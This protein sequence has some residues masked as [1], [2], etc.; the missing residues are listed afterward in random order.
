MAVNYDTGVV[1][2]TPITEPNEIQKLLGI[3]TNNYADIMLADSINPYSRK[4]PTNSSVLHKLEDWQFKEANWSY[5][6]PDETQLSDV[7]AFINNGTLPAN[8]NWEQP[9][10]VRGSVNIGFGWYYVKPETWMRGYDFVGYAHNSPRSIFGT[11]DVPAT[12][13]QGTQ[14]MYIVLNKGTFTFNDFLDFDGYQFAVIIVKEGSAT[15][16]IKSVQAPDSTNDYPKITFT[17]AEMN[18]IFS[19]GVGKYKVYAAAALG[20]FDNITRGGETYNSN[21]SCRPLPV[22]AGEI[23]YSS[24][25]EDTEVNIK[26]IDVSIDTIESTDSRLYFTLTAVNESNTALSVAWVFYEILG[27]D[28]FNTDTVIVSKRTLGNTPLSVN[29]PANETVSLGEFNVAH[30][31]YKDLSAPYTL[32]LKI[33]QGKT[34]TISEAR[35]AG[36]D[37]FEYELTL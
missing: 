11:L 7:I 30:T 4:K 27:T 29:V 13:S 1:T 32:T 3:S 34:S 18:Q 21:P 15:A 9:S 12:V 26:R 6:I 17:K 24:S 37:S 28:E 20:D 16:Y 22:T 35:Y 36:E 2:G 25:S 5:K 31:G 33:Y 23:T 8:R 10:S 19:D 14:S